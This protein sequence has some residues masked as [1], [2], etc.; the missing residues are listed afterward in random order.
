[1]GIDARISAASAYGPFATPGRGAVIGRAERRVAGGGSGATLRSRPRSRR[2]PERAGSR[3]IDGTCADTTDCDCWCVAT[4]SRGLVTV[5]STSSAD[6]WPETTRRRSRRLHRARG[7]P[8]RLRRSHRRFARRGRRCWVSA[9]RRHGPER[10]RSGTYRHHRR[11]AVR[12]PLGASPTSA[13][14][15]SPYLEG[16]RRSL[17]AQRAPAT[18]DGHTAEPGRPLAAHWNGVR[19]PRRRETAP[20]ASACRIGRP[21]ERVVLRRRAPQGPLC[22]WMISAA[23]C[24]LSASRTSSATTTALLCS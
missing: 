11:Y 10:T 17:A 22:R 15:G 12:C 18:A 9:Q 3:P 6:R 21:R 13:R 8:A 19:R 7:S 14:I 16:R 20:Q 2:K 5:R 24:H 1:M 4:L 23:T